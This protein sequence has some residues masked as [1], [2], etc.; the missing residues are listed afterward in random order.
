MKL[1]VDVPS[2]FVPT[3]YFYLADMA[4]KHLYELMQYSNSCESKPF[5]EFYKIYGLD[6][7]GKPDESILYFLERY[8]K[9]IKSLKTDELPGFSRILI[10]DVLLERRVLIH[11]GTKGLV[12]W[13]EFGFV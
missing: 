8:R 1:V 10:R 5:L 9:R 7:S 13:I 11:G 12:R 6:R 2:I 3:N 4:G